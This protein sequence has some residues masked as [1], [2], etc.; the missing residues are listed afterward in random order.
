MPSLINSTP[1]HT[2]I[3]LYGLILHLSLQVTL[4]TSW[5]IRCI[6]IG[7]LSTHP[8]ECNIHMSMT[9]SP[10]KILLNH[11]KLEMLKIKEVHKHNS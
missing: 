2:S 1:Q 5:Y 3:I 8:L 4:T 10:I 6:F 7:L 11:H 9:I